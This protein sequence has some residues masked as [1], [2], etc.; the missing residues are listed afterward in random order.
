MQ[1][2][3]EIQRYPGSL[4]AKAAVVTGAGF[5]ISRAV[6]LALPERRE[7]GAGGASGRQTG[8]DCELIRSEGRR[9]F[10]V[11]ADVTDLQGLREA[12]LEAS[13]A[14]DHLEVGVAAAGVNAWGHL[15]ELTP[16]SQR[17]ALATNVEGVANLARLLLPGMKERERGKFIVLASHN[18]HGPAPGGSGCVASKFGTGGFS[19][20][21]SQET[22][23]ECSSIS[24]SQGAWTPAGIRPTRRHPRERM[25]SSDDV[26]L[27]VLF[28]ATLPP[29]LS[30]GDVMVPPRG[31]L[32]GALG[33]RLPWSP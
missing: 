25:L 21:L 10:P 1:V 15:S 5:G 18:G 32:V 22:A 20:S 12:V 11:P 2:S 16:D 27:V 9:A 28:L 24:S 26:A 14:V 3:D 4:D 33:L 7:R 19:L 30:L 8:R 13:R 23:A 31:L 29:H 17:H 6:A